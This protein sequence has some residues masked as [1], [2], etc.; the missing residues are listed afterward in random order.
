MANV[1]IRSIRS[2]I[3]TLFPNII[4][5]I[6]LK[7]NYYN[8]IRALQIK[9]KD[10]GIMID[11]YYDDKLFLISPYDVIVYRMIKELLTNTYKHSDG[12]SGTV[13]LNVKGQII[14][15]TIMNDG[16]PIDFELL[17]NNKSRG[18]KTIV[19]EVKQLEGKIKVGNS[20]NQVT[21]TIQIP[22]KGENTYET[23]IN[24]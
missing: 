2:E 22:I 5:D 21:V 11:F 4:H 17:K 20:N 13:Y 1:I 15:L 24:R 7:E 12:E 3:D 6:S 8:I 10:K 9:Y 16:V 18:I 14:Y 23:F 19:R